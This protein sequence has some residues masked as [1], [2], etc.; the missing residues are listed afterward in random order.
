MAFKYA[1]TGNFS[2]KTL[3]LEN[4]KKLLKIQTIKKHFCNDKSV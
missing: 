4:I 2:A 3:I 1:G